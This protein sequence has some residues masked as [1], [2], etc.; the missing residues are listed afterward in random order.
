MPKDYPLLLRVQTRMKALCS[1]TA[2][3][4]GTWVS[5]V[6]LASYARCSDRIAIDLSID[7]VRPERI[8]SSGLYL[9]VK[10]LWHSETGCRWGSSVGLTAA[11]IGDHFP[12]YEVTTSLLKETEE[13]K[14]RLIR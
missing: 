7:V 11:G 13:L 12:A 4:P 5:E 1:R 8:E 10:F 14:S 6:P 2:G 3:W 9:V